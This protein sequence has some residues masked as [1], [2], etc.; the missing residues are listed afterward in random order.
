MASGR[1]LR[2]LVGQSGAAWS[3][4]FSPDGQ[5]LASGA[6][7]GAVTLWDV[8]SGRELRTLS[9]HSSDVFSVAF[10]PDGHMLASGSG[11]GTVR[12]W[13]PSSGSEKVS[14]VAFDDGSYLAIT[15][16]GFFDS[17]SAQAEEISQRPRRRS[18]LRHRVLSREVLSARFGQ[19]QPGWRVAH[20][21]RQHR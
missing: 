6:M 20:R 7:T 5:L 3:V 1:E 10:S 2:T 9:G 17:S 16:E 14:L 12:L 13:D 18:R 21:L 8:A 15:P 11:D 4:A 19:A